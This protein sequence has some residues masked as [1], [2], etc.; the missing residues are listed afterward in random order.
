MWVDDHDHWKVVFV[1]LSMNAWNTSEG[2]DSW[3]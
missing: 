1:Q 3:L 2:D